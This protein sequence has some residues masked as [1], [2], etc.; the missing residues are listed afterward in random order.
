VAATK[1]EGSQIKETRK[2]TPWNRTAPAD[3]VNDHQALDNYDYDFDFKDVGDGMASIHRRSK[4]RP[5][6]AIV[7]QRFLV[8]E[9]YGEWD[10]KD[11]DKEEG[12]NEDG[13]QEMDNEVKEEKGNEVHSEVNNKVNG[14]VHEVKDQENLED[15]IAKD[16]H[17]NDVVLDDEEVARRAREYAKHLSRMG[18]APPPKHVGCNLEGDDNW[19]FECPDTC[20]GW[21]EYSDWDFDSHSD[22]DP[23]PAPFP[24]LQTESDSDDA[25]EVEGFQPTYDSDSS[26]EAS[27]DELDFPRLVAPTPRCARFWA[28]DTPLNDADEELEDTVNAHLVYRFRSSNN[29][30]PEDSPDADAVMFHNTFPRRAL[31]STAATP[32]WR[33]RSLAGVC[34]EPSQSGG[35][36]YSEGEEEITTGADGSN[37]GPTHAR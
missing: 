29:S 14:Q 15:N 3:P 16:E 10:Y 30:G 9:E 24:V 32:R 31:F 19:G 18:F 28:R 27:D 7:I 21:N 36:F 20:I 4:G 34:E 35:G 5:G 37:G 13:K 33:E 6:L 2:V 1:E 26:S 22:T 25:L 8:T 12:K 17:Q 23:E 11:D